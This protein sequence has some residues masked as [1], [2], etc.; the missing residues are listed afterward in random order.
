MARRI[1]GGFERGAP[2]STFYLGWIPELYRE[3]ALNLTSAVLLLLTTHL[4]FEED[5]NGCG[6]AWAWCPRSEMAEFLGVGEDAI[7]KAVSKLKKAGSISE[8]S[9]ACRGHAAEYWVCPDTPWPGRGTK[10]LDDGGQP[11]RRKV[12]QNG[13]ERL[14]D[15]GQAIRSKERG[16]ITGWVEA[17][18]DSGEKNL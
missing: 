15:G 4:E 9:P 3:G 6:K 5:G 18:R 17:T 2:F 13:P 14:D 10:R 1:S 11:I 8:K 7:S 16:G 12:V